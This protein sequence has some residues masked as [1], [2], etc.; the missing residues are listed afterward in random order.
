MSAD[1]HLNRQQFWHLTSR[2][3]F[4]PSAT[5][6]PRAGGGRRNADQPTLYATTS[7]HYW[8][9][10]AGGADG[11]PYGAGRRWAAEIEPTE[12]HPPI[13]HGHQEVVLDPTKVRVKRIIPT[14]EAIKETTGYDENNRSV[15]RGY[16]Y[17]GPDFPPRRRRR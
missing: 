16:R 5:V 13:Q 6:R 17:Q 7:P 3:D 12:D 1:E 2:K 8:A 15:P 9:A 10:V 11:K 4:K 14:T